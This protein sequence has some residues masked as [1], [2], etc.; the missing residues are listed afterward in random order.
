MVKDKYCYPGTDVLINKFDIRDYQELERVERMFT[1]KRM[2]ELELKPIASTFDL[3]HLQKI[4]QH[5]FKDLYDWA[6]KTRDV[7][8]IKG[9]SYFCPAFQ[10]KD[11]SDEIFK[12]LK[13]EK[14][15]KGLDIE[16]FSE[17]AAYYLGE[18]NSTH[19]FRE[20]NGRTQREFIRNLAQKNGYHLSWDKVD[21]DDFINASEQSHLR[22]NNAPFARV[23]EQCIENRIPDKA[24][25]R[26]FEER[27]LDR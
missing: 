11:Y 2:A 27:F 6:G 17:R 22:G 8:I 23:I 13:S 15:L 3:R 9:N 4:H 19:P 18:I 24:L 5:I 25:I 10:I 16:R 1:A 21:R 20:G 14:F 26:A 12:Q 7:D